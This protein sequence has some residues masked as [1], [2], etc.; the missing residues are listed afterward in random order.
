MRT[1]PVKGLA[2]KLIDR[3]NGTKGAIP[4]C[5]DHGEQEA[6]VLRAVADQALVWCAQCGEVL[7]MCAKSELESVRE[8][9]TRDS[10]IDTNRTAPKPGTL[11]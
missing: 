5:P 1:F 9:V 11:G 10:N 8:Q 4:V 7:E 2:W 6:R 3:N